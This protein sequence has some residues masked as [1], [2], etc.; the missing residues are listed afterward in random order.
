MGAPPTVSS[1]SPADTLAVIA[2]EAINR[3]EFDRM[4][5]RS[6][7]DLQKKGQRNYLRELVRFRGLLAAGRN[8]GYDRNPAVLARVQPRLREAL[9][10]LVY[11]RRKSLEPP[12]TEDLLRQEYAKRSSLFRERES[13]EIR[14]VTASGEQD[15]RDF[16][17]AAREAGGLAALQEPFRSRVQEAGRIFLGSVPAQLWHFLKSQPSGRLSEP[18]LTASGWRLFLVEGY[19]PERQLSFEEVR[20]SLHR[21]LQGHREKI[22]F[23]SLLDECHRIAPVQLLP[24]ALDDPDP[25][26]VVARVGN[27]N[28]TRQE[29]L[30]ALKSQQEVNRRI[31]TD[32]QGRNLLLQN[33]AQR[34]CMAQL[35][36]RTPEIQESHGTQIAYLR[37]REV[38][39]TL[40]QQECYSRVRVDDAEARRFYQENIARFGKG[41]VLSAHILLRPDP[42]AERK[43]RRVLER[44]RAGEEF[45]ALARE[46]SEDKATGAKGGELGW[47]ARGMLVKEYEQAAFSMQPG[48]ITSPSVRSLYG[49]HVIHVKQ[50][51]QSLPFEQVREAV[52]K[53]LTEKR[54]KEAYDAFVERTMA[55]VGVQLFP[56]ELPPD[57]VPEKDPRLLSQQRI[58]I[59][60][61]GTIEFHGADD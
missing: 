27:V 42:E 5:Q 10:R 32:A 18:Y 35:A 47:F 55:E 22:L 53:E 19:R 57:P 9:A 21:E 7:V 36:L 49:Y 24:E 38:V 60:S 51:R 41:Q 30:Q 59:T 46:L 58:T 37:D 56:D 34:E 61:Q 4:F 11:D 26:E 44:L 45:A 1:T 23:R 12:L 13:L 40:L 31:F 15:A 33:L 28:I 6:P 48:Q 54:R 39:D 25:L 8:K 16:L 43:S 20:D 17:A 52:V 50:V 3:G 29:F 2:G 14:S